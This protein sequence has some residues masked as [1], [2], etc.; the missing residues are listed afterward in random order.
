MFDAVGNA[1]DAGGA[2]GRS[3]AKT[4]FPQALQ[5]VFNTDIGRIPWLLLYRYGGN[6]SRS[7]KRAMF[8]Y[9]TVGT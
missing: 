8:R 4:E 2:C 9:V 1:T 5:A 6:C 7:V 3:I